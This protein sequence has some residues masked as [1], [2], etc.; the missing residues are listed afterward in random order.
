MK[1]IC[2]FLRKVKAA[3]LAFF[4]GVKEIAVTA[5][6]VVAEVVRRDVGYIKVRVKNP[7]NP[8]YWLVGVWS[9]WEMIVMFPLCVYWVYD[10]MRIT[11]AIHAER[12]FRFSNWLLTDQTQGV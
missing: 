8:W 2:N 1:T 7:I 3:A 12:A 11:R 10:E 4:R 5:K 9:V 6:A